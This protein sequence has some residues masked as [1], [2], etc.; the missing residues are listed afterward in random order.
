MDWAA[1]YEECHRH[2]P[3]YNRFAA[4]EEHEIIFAFPAPQTDQIVEGLGATHGGE[5]A[6][7]LPQGWTGSPTCPSSS[8]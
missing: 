6:T 4:T 3:L 2:L 8:R 5:A 7:P 1:V